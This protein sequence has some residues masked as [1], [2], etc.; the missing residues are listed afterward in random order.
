MSKGVIA[1]DPGIGGAIALLIDGEYGQVYDMPIELKQSGRKQVDPRGLIDV[2]SELA[3]R[4]DSVRCVVEQ[5]S[6]MPSQGVSSQFSLGDSFGS[7]R[8]AAALVAHQ[9]QLVVPARWKRAMHLTKDKGYSLTLARRLFPA[10]RDE[11]KLAKHEGRAEALLL[12]K[13]GYEA[14]QW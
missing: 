12:A 11:L 6:A 3:S 10:A 13:Y 8:T 1:I 4:V 9:L 5:V 14:L 2:L 7:A